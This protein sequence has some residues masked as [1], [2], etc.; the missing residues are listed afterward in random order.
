[1]RE[2]H[3]ANFLLPNGETVTSLAGQTHDWSVMQAR[4]MA[5]RGSGVSIGIID[6]PA[7][8]ARAK[9]VVQQIR[10]RL[11]LHERRISVSR[12]DDVPRG[13]SLN[14]STAS[15]TAT[16]CGARASSSRWRTISRV[17]A[18]MTTMTEKKLLRVLHVGVANRG[19]W[20]LKLCN[21]RPASRRRR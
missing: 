4:S 2:L 1:M 3:D 16:A 13:E 19:E 7:N 8:P 17:E 9:P 11:Q 6:H 12:P 14:F 21:P 20:P 10:Q 15:S 5:G 18:I